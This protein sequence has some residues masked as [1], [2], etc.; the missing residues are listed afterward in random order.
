MAKKRYNHGGRRPGA[1]RKPLGEENMKRVDVLL[2]T[3]QIDLAKA[4]G[5]E[6]LSA[7]VRFAIDKT[8]KERIRDFFG[9]EN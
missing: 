3:E 9:T 6:N 7:G 2:T 5:N 8:L 4:L 1:G